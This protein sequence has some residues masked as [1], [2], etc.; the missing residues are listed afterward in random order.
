MLPDLDGYEICRHLR[1]TTL[2]SHI[3]I[4]FL[5]GKDGRSDKIAGLELGADDYV[6]KPFDIEEL[7]LRVKNA[8][9]S[10][11][12]QNMT[13]PC[14]GLP[15][16]RL[17]E[18]QLRKIVGNGGW[19]YVELGLDHL[20]PFRDAYGFVA[21]DEVIRYSAFLLSEV[22]EQY[23]TADDFLGQSSDQSFVLITY[24][25]HPDKLIE[26]LR[27]RFDQAIGT[28]YNFIDSEQ[29]GI[30]R[31]DG[32]LVPLIRLNVGTVSH[33]A[34]PFTDIREIT[35]AAAAQRRQL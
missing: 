29:G 18:D 10:H 35:E 23:G 16:G 22:V 13:N 3:P 21:T 24:A 1:T 2:T 8:I 34:G 5:T 30:R 7:G 11:K 19:S 17:I 15:S 20:E 26:Q 4:I 6:T 9:A 28:H 32:T 27:E 31:E 33:E 12:R 14:T 25:K